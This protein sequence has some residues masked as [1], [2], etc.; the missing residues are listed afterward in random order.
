MSALLVENMLLSEGKTGEFGLLPLLEGSVV[1]AGKSGGTV[2]ALCPA[3]EVAF[4]L[5]LPV[6]GVE[7]EGILVACGLF[8]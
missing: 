5:P 1:L 2:A 3:S 8:Q 7:G 4:R 6:D